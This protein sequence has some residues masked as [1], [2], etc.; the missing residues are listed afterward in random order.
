[1]SKRDIYTEIFWGSDDIELSG[2]CFGN[3]TYGPLDLGA[4]PANHPGKENSN[5]RR[6]RN[7]PGTLEYGM[8]TLRVDL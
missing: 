2:S 8:G 4:Q 1:M 6:R 7:L 5:L 3:L